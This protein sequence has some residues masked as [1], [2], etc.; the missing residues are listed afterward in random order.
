M[1]L[2]VKVL[3][4]LLCCFILMESKIYKFKTPKIILFGDSEF[5]YSFSGGLGTQL[6]IKYGSKADII[7]RGLSGYNTNR[8]LEALNDLITL[9][10]Y[11][12]SEKENSANNLVIVMFGDNDCSIESQHVDVEKY[13]KNLHTIITNIRDLG[14]NYDIILMTP[15]PINDI[16]WK[17]DC[18]KSGRP[19]DRYNKDLIMYREAMIRTAE[20][21]NVHLIDIWGDSWN[22]TLMY[23]DGLHPTTLGYTFIAE[24]LYD[25]LKSNLPNWHYENLPH[26]RR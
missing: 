12:V 16:L 14:S 24:R 9:K 10:D 18:E 11:F 26:P 1:K 20:T 2:I 19:V 13:I 5:E 21:L 17:E 22:S 4:S 8:G 3:I 7:N 23:T 6:T 25:Y 15:V